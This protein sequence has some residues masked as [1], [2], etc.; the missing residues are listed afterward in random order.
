MKRNGKMCV[1]GLKVA[2]VSEPSSGFP[3]WL[4]TVR[5]QLCLQ[6]AGGTCCR[7]IPACNSITCQTRKGKLLLQWIPL[8]KSVSH[9]FSI[10][11]KERAWRRLLPP[12]SSRLTWGDHLIASN[13]RRCKVL[14]LSHR[15][16][17]ADQAWLVKWLHAHIG[18]SV[19]NSCRAVQ[20]TMH[21][22]LMAISIGTMRHYYTICYKIQVGSSKWIIHRSSSTSLN[23]KMSNYIE[24]QLAGVALRGQVFHGRIPVHFQ[25]R[26]NQMSLF[27]SRKQ[28][29]GIWPDNPPV[30]CK[31]DSADVRFKC[32][33]VRERT[34]SKSTR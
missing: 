8:S 28:S 12:L 2:A 24:T 17:Q 30:I 33:S 5:K 16:V 15:Y 22:H 10:R 29:S 3:G 7:Y 20:Y 13:L 4:R 26:L 27:K 34:S 21:H 23:W 11:L 6:P 18:T 1:C 32:K 9:A 25:S 31:P 14:S 19:S